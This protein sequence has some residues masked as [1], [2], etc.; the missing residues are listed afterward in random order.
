MRG[1][2]E[3]LLAC[4]M[5]KLMCGD[6]CRPSTFMTMFYKITDQPYDREVETW[7]FEPRDEVV[8]EMIGSSE[9]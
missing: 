9:G 7:Q 3:I 2:I 6:L 1:L 5:S 8:C 4:L